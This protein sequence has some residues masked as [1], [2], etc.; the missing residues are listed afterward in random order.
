VAWHT[1]SSHRQSNWCTPWPVLLLLL[2]LS[3]WASSSKDIAD[4]PAGMKNHLQTLGSA[5]QGGERL[6]AAVGEFVHTLWQVDECS[7]NT[8]LEH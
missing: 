8:E 3:V 2:L 6:K 4:A 7:K 5:G 1:V